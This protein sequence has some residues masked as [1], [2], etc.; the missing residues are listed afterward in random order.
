MYCFTKSKLNFYQFLILYIHN[1]IQ[2]YRFPAQY[3]VMCNIS[4]FPL[5]KDNK[6]DYSFLLFRGD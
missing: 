6:G 5:M 1:S 2:I 4:R 3:K